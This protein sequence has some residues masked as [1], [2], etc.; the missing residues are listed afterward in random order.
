MLKQQTSQVGNTIYF[1]C[2]IQKKTSHGKAC[3]TQQAVISM[4]PLNA[5]Q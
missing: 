2:S 3:Y 5:Q 1:T 4:M